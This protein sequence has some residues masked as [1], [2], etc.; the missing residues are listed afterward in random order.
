E[1]DPEQQRHHQTAP[2][3][4]PVDEVPV[5]VAPEDRRHGENEKERN[6]RALLEADRLDRVQRHEA[7]DRADRVLVDERRDDEPERAGM[8][9]RV[10][11]GVAD[12]AERLTPTD[13]R[14]T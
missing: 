1:R 2:G 6:L 10:A 13:R 3:T 8:L 4:Q 7:D 11:N 14:A 5:G 12:L 9:P